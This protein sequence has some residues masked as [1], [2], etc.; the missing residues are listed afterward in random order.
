MS[1]LLLDPLSFIELSKFVALQCLLR[2][3]PRFTIEF[4]VIGVVFT[5]LLLTRHINIYFLSYAF[6]LCIPCA[7]C[8]GSNSP[9]RVRK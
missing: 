3:P 2:L 6:T 9:S 8:S 7:L 4:Q 1:H 5:Y